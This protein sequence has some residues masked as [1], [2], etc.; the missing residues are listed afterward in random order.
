MEPGISSFAGNPELAGQSLLPLIAFAMDLL[1]GHKEKWHIY[2]IYL[3]ATG[4]MREVPYA[5]REAIM[6]NIR[7]VTRVTGAME[8]ALMRVSVSRSCT[9]SLE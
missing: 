4:G 2:P 5:Q 7:L 8:P 9:V 1:Q 6:D 3:K